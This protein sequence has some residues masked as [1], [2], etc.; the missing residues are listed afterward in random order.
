MDTEKNNRILVFFGKYAKFCWVIFLM[1]KHALKPQGFEVS[2]LSGW[3]QNPKKVGWNQV[4]CNMGPELIVVN[5][6]KVSPRNLHLPDI[7]PI[8]AP[9]LLGSLWADKITDSKWL[10]R[11]RYN[12][13]TPVLFWRLWVFH[14]HLYY[15][16]HLHLPKIWR[17]SDHFSPLILPTEATKTAPEDFETRCGGAMY[18]TCQRSRLQSVGGRKTTKEMGEGSFL[19]SWVQWLRKNMGDEWLY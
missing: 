17:S 6:V 5:G 4:P 8:S 15:L 16:S 14:H 12:F 19:K 10:G 18:W 3:K 11:C 9:W 7:L 1:R 13:L 2:Q